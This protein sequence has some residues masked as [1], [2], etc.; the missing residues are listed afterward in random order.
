MERTIIPWQNFKAFASNWS[1]ALELQTI[2]FKWKQL[3]SAPNSFWQKPLQR[4][5]DLLQWTLKE[6]ERALVFVNQSRARAFSF[7]LLLS[8]WRPEKEIKP[9]SRAHSWLQYSYLGNLCN[10]GGVSLHWLQHNSLDWLICLIIGIYGWT[11]SLQRCWGWY[12]HHHTRTGNVSAVTS[13]NGI[14]SA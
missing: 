9:T 8:L 14:L 7:K 3:I 6:V 4:K 5:M 1:V 11:H 13:V 12:H 2:P 10:P